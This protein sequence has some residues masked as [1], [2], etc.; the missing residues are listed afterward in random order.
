MFKALVV[1]FELISIFSHIRGSKVIEIYR[2]SQEIVI[3]R[4]D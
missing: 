2:I 3:K 4:D 1:L